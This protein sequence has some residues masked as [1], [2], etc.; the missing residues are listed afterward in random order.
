MPSDFRTRNSRDWLQEAIQSPTN[1]AIASQAWHSLE[2]DYKPSLW[3]NTRAWLTRR[4]LKAALRSFDWNLV[5]KFAWRLLFD[6]PQN[7]TALLGLV[8][9][10]VHVQEPAL[11]HWCLARMRFERLSP[12]ERE[13][14]ALFYERVGAFVEANC[15]RR[16]A[17]V[18]AKE[19]Q[20]L[21][22]DPKQGSRPQENPP[23]TED[24]SDV[25]ASDDVPTQIRSLAEQADFDA[26]HALAETATATSGTS[27]GVLE[28]IED[29]NLAEAKY[30]LELAKA[31]AN[32][33]EDVTAWSEM[34]RREA[35]EQF[36]RVQISVWS[37]RVE[38]SPRDLDLKRKLARLLAETDRLDMAVRLLGEV[39]QSRPTCEAW[40]LM[41]ECLQKQRRFPKALEAYRTAV[42]LEASEPE[43]V[44]AMYRL[45]V[46]AEASGQ[47]KE[48]R[49]AFA[50]VVAQDS[51][52]RDAQARLDKLNENR[53]TS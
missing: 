45:G 48:A 16:W 19:T 8:A 18:P 2:Q 43:R 52:Y 34:A 12:E 53:D 31:G 50:A 47:D 51:M 20:P 46:L 11:V 44:L 15:L 28:A 21:S 23:G 42:T 22:E 38:R 25:V 27:L 14:C 32:G 49:R 5:P 37:G 1:L 3:R 26:A 10:G 41:G 6:S 39:V 29:L 35:E 4:R 9:F 17:P 30:N 24:Q 36:R 40:T 33:K 7:A 13:Q